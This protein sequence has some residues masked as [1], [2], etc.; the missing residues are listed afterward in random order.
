MLPGTPPHSPVTQR[1]TQPGAAGLS[2]PVSAQ[3]FAP[4]AACW[5]ALTVHPKHEQLAERG[6]KNHGFE[7]YLPVH[8]LRRQWSDRRKDLDMVLFPGYVFCRFDPAHKL[9]V[10]QSPAVRSIVSSGREPLPV[11][12][13]EI[14]SVRAVIA[15]GRPVDLCPYMRVGQGV[16]VR[17]GPFEAVRGV[18]ARVKDS[19]R[20]VVSVEAL[21]CSVAV[22]VD[23]DQV[24]PEP[25]LR[26][27][28]RE[29]MADGRYQT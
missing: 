12:E 5:F 24:T 14:S 23:A 9:R 16:R 19:W 11:D 8:R 18:I 2:S 28:L 22:E 25:V 15:S 6:L 17:S 29:R 1:A 20:V 4:G 13:A 27:L 7:A 26:D 3:F 21:G 10:L